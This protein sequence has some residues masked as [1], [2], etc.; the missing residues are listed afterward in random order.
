[1]NIVLLLFYPF[2]PSLL[3]NEMP[4]ALPDS[5]VVL[6]YFLLFYFIFLSFHRD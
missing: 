4:T 2:S 1:M 6:S 3:V 5:C